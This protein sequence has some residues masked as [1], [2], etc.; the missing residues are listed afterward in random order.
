MILGVSMIAVS[1]SFTLANA[2]G[3]SAQTLFDICSQASGQCWS[4]TSYCPAPG[5]LENIPSTNNYEPGFAAAM[6]LKDL[7]LAQEAS[8]KTSVGSVLGKQAKQLYQ[9]FVEMGNADKDFSGIIE[10]LSVKL[11]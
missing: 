2:L 11:K 5:V 9:R 6:M 1:E 10:M 3:L 8:E 7:N 4:L